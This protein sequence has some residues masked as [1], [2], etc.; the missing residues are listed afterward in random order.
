MSKKVISRAE[1]RMMCLYYE[2]LYKAL[3]AYRIDGVNATHQAYLLRSVQSS[4]F[5]VQEM[6]RDEPIFDVGCDAEVK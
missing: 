4:L 2:S 1:L 3:K 6:L 5:W